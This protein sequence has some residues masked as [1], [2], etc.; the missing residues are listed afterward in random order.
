MSRPVLLERVRR[1]NIVITYSDGE[2]ASVSVG[3]VIFGDFPDQPWPVYLEVSEE[4]GCLDHQKGRLKTGL[5]TCVFEV[6]AITCLA[7]PQLHLH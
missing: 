2:G 6:E 7:I 5:Q 3:V 4:L 1:S